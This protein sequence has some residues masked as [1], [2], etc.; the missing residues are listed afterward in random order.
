M[1]EDLQHRL[2]LDHSGM[3]LLEWAETLPS[4]EL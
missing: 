3:A 4:A 1:R 2:C